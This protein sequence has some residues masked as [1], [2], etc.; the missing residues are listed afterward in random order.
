MKKFT[1]IALAAVALLT[2]QACKSQ[3]SKNEGFTKGQIDSVS[4]AVGSYFGNMLKHDDFGNLNLNVV[5]QAIQD[6]LND[7][8]LKIK[9]EEIGMVIQGYIMKRQTVVGEQNLRKGEEFLAKNKTKEGV[10]ELENGLQYK[11]LEE[12]SGV[13]P[14]L[15][16]TVVVY[17]AGSL[18]DGFEFDS[19]EKHGGQPATFV[20]NHG[21]VISGWVE[22]LQQINEGSKAVL[23]IPTELA[24]NVYPP[25]RE[26]PVNAV[27]IFEVQLLEVKKAV[28]QP[29]PKKK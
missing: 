11:I 5:Q 6:V 3:S 7:K 10:V 13:K 2:V 8:E 14:Q 19:S 27:L 9:Q 15:G 24:Y 29:E 26:I 16:D 21:A 18:I 28:A 1:F 20:L 25:T 23:Y 4:Y 17:Y 12:G 22:G